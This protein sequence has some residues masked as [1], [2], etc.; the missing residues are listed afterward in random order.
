MICIELEK[1][2][3]CQQ[4][5]LLLSKAPPAAEA[6]PAVN[7]RGSIWSPALI[8]VL[9]FTIWKRCGRP[10]M[11]T[12]YGNPMVS[13]LL[14]QYQLWAFW[15]DRGTYANAAATTLFF[16]RCNGNI[17]SADPERLLKMCSQNP[18]L[19]QQTTETTKVEII[20]A[21]F[22]GYFV[23]A[24]WSAKARRAVAASRSAKPNQSTLNTALLR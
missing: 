2:N 21:L 6:T 4:I 10:M 20:G 16:T 22:Q 13:A 8:G 17:G 24:S 15:D 23:P 7:I 12:I 9:P 3:T 11:I 18:K 5:F 1:A 19:T 14:H